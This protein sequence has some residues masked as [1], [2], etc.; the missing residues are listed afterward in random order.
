MDKEAILAASRKENK[1][2][3]YAKMEVS[4]LALKVGGFVGLVVTT[5][6]FFFEEYY[7]EQ[8][9]NYGYSLIIFSTAF[10]AILTRAYRKRSFIDLFLAVICV[11]PLVR[12]FQQ[13][14]G[15]F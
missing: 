12:T 10:A 9:L 4:S 5:A 11:L 1:Q 8:P 7:L 6:L 15:Q 3:D 13:Y 14:L 2:R